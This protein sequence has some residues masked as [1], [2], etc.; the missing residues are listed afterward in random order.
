MKTN[1][2]TL[3]CIGA[4]LLNGCSANPKKT[5]FSEDSPTMESILLGGSYGSHHQVQFTKEQTS[6]RELKD[7]NS[8][9]NGHKNVFAELNN[10]TLLLYIEPHKTAGGSFIPGFTVPLKMYD[11]V[12]FALPGER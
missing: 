10:P 1:V 4:L 8:S 9:I 6:E 2:T 7:H 12:Q 11:R 3:I 5:I